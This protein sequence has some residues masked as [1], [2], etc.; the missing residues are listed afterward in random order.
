MAD[1]V[2]P[3]SARDETALRHLAQKYRRILAGGQADVRDLCFNAGARREHLPLPAPT[4]P[5]HEVI[6][7]L[8]AA[9]VDAVPPLHDGPWARAT[10]EVC[11]ALLR[12]AREAR[13]VDLPAG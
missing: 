1:L 3:I 4:V 11:L 6:D 10:L 8:H 7:E 13:D 5:R 9:V 2:L 12:S